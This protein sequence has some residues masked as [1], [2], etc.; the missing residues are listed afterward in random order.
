M[1]RGDRSEKAPR[2]YGIAAG[3]VGSI[4]GFVL[5]GSL[6][7]D[8][9][10]KSLVVALVAAGPQ[11]FVEMWWKRRRR[12]GEEQLLVLSQPSDLVCGHPAIR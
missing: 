5:A 10:T 11:L 1:W 3:I 9:V 4:L 7:A 12:R 2:S 8:H 6:G